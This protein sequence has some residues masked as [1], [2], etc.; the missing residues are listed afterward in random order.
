[1]RDILLVIVPLCIASVTVATAIPITRDYV[2][3][4]ALTFGGEWLLEITLCIND[5]TRGTRGYRRGPI[6]R[7]V[8]RNGKAWTSRPFAQGLPHQEQRH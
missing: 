4:L 2:V 1:M 5:R 7:E 8:F 3:Q 6:G